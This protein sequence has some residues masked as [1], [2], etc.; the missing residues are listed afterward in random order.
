VA[1]NAD[2]EGFVL[3]NPSKLD[4][5]AKAKFQT[6]AG[7]DAPVVA[8]YSD[9]AQKADIE[10]SFPKAILKMYGPSSDSVI[11]SSNDEKTVGAKIGAAFLSPNGGALIA[12][13]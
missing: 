13:K 6:A 2:S 4:S 8:F 7:T 12:Q 10:K 5:N 9:P 3:Y 1:R 11:I